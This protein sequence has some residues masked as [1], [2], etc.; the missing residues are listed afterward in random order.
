[1]I[2]PDHRS[3][4]QLDLLI[5]QALA[6]S[7]ANEEPPAHVWDRIRAQL[8]RSQRSTTVQWSGVVLQAALLLLMVVL[9]STMVW[10]EQLVE[11]VS[12]VSFDGSSAASPTWHSTDNSPASSRTAR[13]WTLTMYGEAPPQTRPRITVSAMEAVEIAL[14]QNYASA[15]LHTSTSQQNRRRAS[16]VAT[17]SDEI[18][19]DPTSLQAKVLFLRSLRETEPAGRETRPTTQPAYGPELMWQ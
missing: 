18:P 4:D 15:Q 2:S 11:R 8:T 3:S 10:Q 1:M 16:N 14:L 19:P 5:R 13:I 9:G 6:E 17:P 12:V 7:V